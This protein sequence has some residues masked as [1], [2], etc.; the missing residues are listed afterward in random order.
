MIRKC[1]LS[2]FANIYY[3]WKKF[4]QLFMASYSR[5][6]DPGAG[7]Y[8][9]QHLL[10]RT[11]TNKISTFLYFTTKARMG[12]VHRMGFYLTKGMEN[13]YFNRATKSLHLISAF[14]IM[15]SLAL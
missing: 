5:S 13:E 4:A 1:C 8:P 3:G 7:V 14:A 6:Y 9:F 11:S 10:L 15:V 2:R 12:K